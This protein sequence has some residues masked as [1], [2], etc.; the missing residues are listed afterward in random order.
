LSDIPAALPTRSGRNDVQ[1]ARDIGAAGKQHRAA[2]RARQIDPKRKHELLLFR[3]RGSTKLERAPREH[4]A[5]N[6]A[7]ICL[8]QPGLAEAKGN[9]KLHP[10]PSP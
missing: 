5:C 3:V 9:V 10:T 2:E 4:Y 1:L 7:E 8:G 6:R